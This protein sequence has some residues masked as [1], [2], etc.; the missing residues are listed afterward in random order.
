MK[1]Y[2]STHQRGSSALSIAA[3][4]RKQA[5][6]E[7]VHISMRYSRILSVLLLTVALHQL[8]AFQSL[9]S[10]RC[11]GGTRHHGGARHDGGLDISR[12]PIMALKRPVL[13]TMRQSPLRVPRTKQWWRR[14]RQW[15]SQRFSRRPGASLLRMAGLFLVALTIR[16]F[17]AVAS[18]GMGRITANVPPLER[19]VDSVVR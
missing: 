4:E 16:P 5:H 10:F 15:V 14:S 9:A 12:R 7:W 19:C 8:N 1:K 17:R 6:C 2:A 18:G 11:D 3:I 13:D